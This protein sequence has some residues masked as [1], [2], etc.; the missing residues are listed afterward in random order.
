M[1]I[2]IPGR[3]LTLAIAALLAFPVKASAGMPSIGL[4]E[5]AQLRIETISFFLVAF[6]LCSAFVRAIWNGLRGDFPRLPDL[7]YRRAVM[8]VGIWGLLFLL[9]LTMISGAR[10]CQNWSASA[11]R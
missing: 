7:T 8:L 1:T 6:L 2:R 4:S 10:Q 5:I 9:V 11:G 3:T